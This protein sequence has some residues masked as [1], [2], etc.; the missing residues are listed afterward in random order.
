MRLG[1]HRG[2]EVSLVIGWSTRVDRHIR[3]ATESPH[4][5]IT[6]LRS[7][8]LGPSFYI[9]KTDL[10]TGFWVGVL[11]AFATIFHPS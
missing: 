11:C 7:A 10:T 3:R 6:G 5:G 9:V 4:N 2:H 8:S 1:I